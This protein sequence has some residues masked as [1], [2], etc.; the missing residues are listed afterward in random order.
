MVPNCSEVEVGREGK[1]ADLPEGTALKV[2]LF[3]LQQSKPVGLSEVRSGAGLSTSSLA[4]YH[5]ER[6]VT[7]GF[8]RKDGAG[9]VADRMALK[10]FMRFR[11]H[12]VSTSLFMAGFFA[13]AL[14]LLF[15][16]PWHSRYQQVAMGAV[17]IFVA[18]VYSVSRAIRSTI[19]L[20]TRAGLGKSGG[21]WHSF[22]RKK[23]T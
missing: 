19:W 15:F 11:N 13:M 16:A 9:F 3:L 12:L 14:V 2:Y 23:K 21:F 18:L 1:E 7:A 22:S 8:A 10:G 6:L 20:R 4:S 5:L 17:V